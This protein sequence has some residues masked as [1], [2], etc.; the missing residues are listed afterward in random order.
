MVKGSRIIYAF[1]AILLILLSGTGFEIAGTEV[2]REAA[3]QHIPSVSHSRIAVGLAHAC[4]VL[5]DDRAR[6]WGNN[7]YGQLGDG[8][9]SNS[10]T[11]V[12]VKELSDIVA[13]ATGAAHSCALMKVGT[14]MCW[15]GNLDGQIGTGSLEITEALVPVK[16]VGI[17]GAK[18]IA[19]GWAHSCAVLSDGTIRCW[20]Q[21]ELG[22]LGN[23][24]KTNSPTPVLAKGATNAVSVATG[25]AH[26][27]ALISDGT[28]TCWGTDGFGVGRNIAVKSP[29]P[30]TVSGVSS[31]VAITVG[32]NFS[33]AVLAEGHVKCWGSN[34]LGQL[35]NARAPWFPSSAVVVSGINTA[36]AIS[37]GL[38]HACALLRNGKLRCWGLPVPFA[39][40][41]ATPQG[42]HRTP[43]E[44]QGI[45]DTKEISAGGHSACAILQ[46]KRVMCWGANYGGQLGNGTSNDSRFP[47]AVKHLGD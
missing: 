45:S 16:V 13:V 23:G 12:V 37:A 24:S 1:G 25:V 18:E 5:P 3:G 10:L 38:F 35:G 8:S 19:A 14:V 46:D 40:K 22:Q 21:N 2:E 41:D 36:T 28:V 27:C 39:G 30:T 9:K 6:C 43:K 20:G 11:A 33:C 31:A 4:T 26:T 47:V 17:S 29:E 7:K 34:I 15:G 32:R 44:V 42:A